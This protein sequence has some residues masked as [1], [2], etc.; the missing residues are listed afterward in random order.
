MFQQAA[1]PGLEPLG[2]DSHAS[3]VHCSVVVF[4]TVPQGQAVRKGERKHIILT[5]CQKSSI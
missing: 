1:G 2:P 3:H 5:Q 4:P